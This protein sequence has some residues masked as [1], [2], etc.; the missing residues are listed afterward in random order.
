MRLPRR[1]ESRYQGRARPV[2]VSSSDL[3][4]VVARQLQ[5]AATMRSP[6]RGATAF[7]SPE[8][9]AG[10]RLLLWGCLLMLVHAAGSAEQRPL[11]L[12]ETNLPLY[13]DR[14]LGQ[15]S[16]FVEVHQSGNRSASS[17][18][19]GAGPELVLW[20]QTGGPAAFPFQLQLLRNGRIF[21]QQVTFVSSA[22]PVT[23]VGLCLL[24]L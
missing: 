11:V 4:Y 2:P 16:G 3:P 23:C 20:L 1:S 13:V 7:R 5:A 19:N 10:G 24:R 9:R 17:R 8:S 22:P 14:Q 15:G 18:P 12:I 21:A 6:E